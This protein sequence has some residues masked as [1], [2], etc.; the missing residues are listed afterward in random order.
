GSAHLLRHTA[1]TLMLENGADLRSLQMFLGHERLNTTQLYTHV[2]IT[3]LKEVH[4]RTHPA[5]ERREAGDGRPEKGNGE[6]E[7][8]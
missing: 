4:E 3:R 8:S 7:S 6:P 2:T 5:K 1:A